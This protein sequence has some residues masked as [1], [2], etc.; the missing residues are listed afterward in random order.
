MGAGAVSQF[1][2][3]CRAATPEEMARA[4]PVLKHQGF[5]PMRNGDWET[6]LSYASVR[7]YVYQGVLEKVL[8]R[9]AV[10]VIEYRSK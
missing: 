5:R 3:Y 9:S 10:A 1:P 6:Q 8:P 7:P 2:P 4:V